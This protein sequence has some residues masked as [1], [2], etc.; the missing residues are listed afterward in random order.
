MMSR[1]RRYQAATLVV[2]TAI[3]ACLEVISLAALFPILS[4]I[5]NP[6][7]QLDFGFIGSVH[8]FVFGS[9]TNQ[10]ITLGI[11]FSILII[12]ASIYR[13]LLVW[14]QIK[15]G[16]AV[17]HDYGVLLFS[18]LISQQYENHLGRN[19]SE[20]ISAITI[21]INQLVG[22]F[23]NPLI[24]IISNLIIMVSMIS[25]LVWISGL[26]VLMLVLLIALIYLAVTLAVKQKLASNSRVLS[27]RANRIIKEVQESFQGIREVI[28]SGTQNKHVIKFSE[29]D[30]DFRN[31][32]A[33]S[34][35]LS[36][37]PRY[38]IE[39]IIVVTLVCGML[40]FTD[41]QIF[42]G[43]MLPLVGVVVLGVQRI[44]PLAQTIYANIATMKGAAVSVH[45][46]VKLNDENLTNENE[47]KKLSRKIDFEKKLELVNVSYRY[48][49]KKTYQLKNISLTIK[50]GDRVGIIGSTGSGKSTLLD[51]ISGLLPPT[52]GSVLIDSKKLSQR[53]SAAWREKLAVVSQK[54]YFSDSNILEN[55]IGF[56]ENPDLNRVKASIDSAQL[57][58]FIDTLPNG[59]LTKVGESGVQM[60]GGQLQRLS[61]ARAI[62][63][64]AD[65]LIFDEATSALDLKTEKK[66]IDALNNLADKVTII[67]VAHR[68]ETLKKCN[69]LF[70]IDNGEI[71]DSGTYSNV[72][73]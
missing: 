35:V 3:G 32:Q 63:R 23:I 28:L 31:A 12:L 51:L 8:E 14:V 5:I 60:S 10:A 52:S 49:S 44:M 11:S 42:E 41:K 57:S 68:V 22:S 40:I 26:W 46:V 7:S 69:L 17:G 30:T 43:E 54:S 45:D 62:Y 9:G 37:A 2:L 53:D 73:R 24:L 4:Y 36:Q 13:V 48:P 38:F 25:M 20:I 70:R 71:V 15:W 29:L 1:R 16:N 34:V 66:V 56:A 47:N 55:I 21:K 65:V 67:Y 64:K 72:I 19:T 33:S 50:K 58:D 18:R 61:I 39:S 59:I 6:N 27:D